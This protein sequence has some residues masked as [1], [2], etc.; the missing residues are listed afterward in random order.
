MIGSPCMCC[1][2]IPLKIFGIFHPALPFPDHFAKEIR[3]RLKTIGCRPSSEEQPP[4]QLAPFAFPARSSYIDD[5]DVLMLRVDVKIETGLPAK[6]TSTV[7]MPVADP[8]ASSPLHL[9]R[10]LGFVI[11]DLIV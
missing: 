8:L 4:L 2:Q 1:F 11:D 10:Y 7:Q 9:S 5:N 3:I 6:A